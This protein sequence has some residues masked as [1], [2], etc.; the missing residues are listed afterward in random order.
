MKNLRKITAI[1]FLCLFFQ[2]IF[3]TEYPVTSSDEI[4]RLKLLPG[5][6]VILQEGEWKDQTIFFKGKGTQENPITLTT[7]NPGK[8]IL[9]GHSTLKI[10][11]EFLVVDGLFFTNGFSLDNDIMSFSKT[12]SNCRITNSSILNYSN[13]DK[14]VDYKWVSLHG[15]KNRVDH[16]SFSGKTHQ[17]TLMVVWLSE[18][19]VPN[20]HQIDNNYFG[21]RPPLEVNGGEIIRVGTSEWS[22][23][24]SFTVIEKNIFDNCD[25]EMETVSIKSGKNKITENLFYECDGTLTLRHGNGN[26]VANNYFIG[27]QKANTG[28]IRIIG[29]NHTVHDNYLQGLSGTNLRA[30]ISIM[31]AVINPELKEYWQVRNASITNNM[32]IDCKEA[33]TIGSGKNETRILTPDGLT[34]INNIVVNCK[35]PYT[36]KDKPKNITLKDNELKGYEEAIEGFVPSFSKFK[37]TNK[38]WNIKGQEKR[39]FW[40]D[41]VVGVNWSTPSFIMKIK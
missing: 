41:E 5:D 11:G 35:K 13:P 14:T 30:A 22:M 15:T 9:S 27:N 10:D 40:E 7:A 6:K 1:T 24:D 12:S 39:F 31:N 34:I 23:K 18:T 19:E 20:Y 25:G 36:L 32:I 3:S 38:I 29:E 8:V 33:I 16:C 37:I 26:E 21:P 17:G 28:G 4:K 2:Q